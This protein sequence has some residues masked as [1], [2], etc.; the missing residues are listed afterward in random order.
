MSVRV[1]DVEWSETEEHDACLFVEDFIVLVDICDISFVLIEPLTR[2][3]ASLIDAI[4][5]CIQNNS[6]GRSK[7]E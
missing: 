3:F 2:E 6:A 5:W 1:D 4:E 7:N